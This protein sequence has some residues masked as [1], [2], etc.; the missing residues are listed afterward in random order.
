MRPLHF[1]FTLISLI[2]LVACDGYKGRSANEDSS[3]KQCG[4]FAK[5]SFGQ[6]LYW[7]PKFPIEILINDSLPENLR[8]S[9]LDAVK[10]WN[11]A[12]Q[13]EVFVVSPTIDHSAVATED[14]NNVIY[15]MADWNEGNK[16]LQASTNLYWTGQE[17]READILLNAKYFKI[18]SS[19]GNDEI[20]FQ[21][22]LVHELGHIFGLDHIE[23]KKSVMVSK[24]GFGE[25]RRDPSD[26]D[27]KNLSCRY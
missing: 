21:S 4:G 5:N 17:T 2:C 25:K 11:D 26:D 20:D 1:L 27:I 23:D 7:Q 24:L 8:T 15:W 16:A 10:Q 6:Q 22:L 19:P 13:F 14:K 9:V 12:T 18:S 3:L